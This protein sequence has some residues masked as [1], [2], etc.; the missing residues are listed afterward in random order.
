MKIVAASLITLT[1]LMVTDR[2]VSDINQIPSHE[3]ATIQTPVARMIAQT[4]LHDKLCSDTKEN[5]T[6]NKV[7]LDDFDIHKVRKIE[8]A[9]RN[10]HVPSLDLEE[11]RIVYYKMKETLIPTDT[12]GK[13][14][15]ELERPIPNYVLSKL[16]K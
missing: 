2:V 14:C 7:Q 6:L 11:T 10:R 3:S 8:N 4:Y 5:I 13:V 1:S 12:V 9:Y 16:N 15:K